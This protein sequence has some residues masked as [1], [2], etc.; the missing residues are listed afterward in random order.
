[1]TNLNVREATEKDLPS[2]LELLSDF[3][4]ASTIAPFLTIIPFSCNCL[5]ISKNSFLSKFPFIKEVLNLDIVEWSGVSLSIE[6]FKNLMKEI[7]SL[8][9]SST[10]VSLK[11]NKV[12][13][14]SIL[15]SNSYEYV[16]FPTALKP[17]LRF[18]RYKSHA[19]ESIKIKCLKM[20]C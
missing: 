13:K 1:M 6:R 11:L 8:I 5:F 17:L 16:G 7:L 15:K 4:E 14:S 3:H 10:F 12:C 18:L 20:N 2:Y 19:K 9:A